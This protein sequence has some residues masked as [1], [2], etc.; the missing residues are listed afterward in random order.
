VKGQTLRDR[1]GLSP[2]E[3]INFR[4]MANTVAGLCLAPHFE[5]LAPEYPSFSVLVTSRNREQYARDALRAIA[6]SMRNTTRQANAVLDALNLLDGNRLNAGQS[7]YVRYILDKFKARPHGQVIN[8]GELLESVDGVDYLAP[9]RYRLEIEWVV[10]LLAALVYSGDIVLAIPGDKFD[11]GKL[12]DLAGTAI[13]DLAAFKHIEPPKD[14]NLPGLQALYELIGL[15]PGLAIEISQGK[16]SSIATLQDKIGTEV[17][18]LVTALHSL[19]E[20]L[21]FW[22]SSVLSEAEAEQYRQQLNTTKTFLESLQAYNTAGKMKNFRHNADDV[23][24][25]EDGLKH[26]AD[27]EKLRS[28]VTELTPLANYLSKAQ[29]VLPLDHEWN[30]RVK[31]ARNDILQQLGSETERGK[32]GFRNQVA[33]RLGEL[34]NEYIRIYSDLYGKARLTLSEDKRK[35]KLLHDERLSRLQALS[36]IEILPQGQ[37]NDFRNRLA[38]LKAAGA[39]SEKDLRADPVP[40]SSDFRP[41][42]EDLSLAAAIK[43]NTLEEQ[44]DQMVGNWTRTLLENLE[45]PTTRH[46]LQ[47]L[48]DDDKTRLDDFITQCELPRPLDDAFVKTLRQVL[49]GL[50]PIEVSADEVNSALFAQASASTVEQLKQRL[51]QFLADKC[52]GQ[53]ISK[54]RIVPK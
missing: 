28:L 46:S 25:H 35:A 31:A 20:R 6:N 48:G 36:T 5:S 4:D 50:V 38:G 11:A 29:A 45:D 37:L 32:S 52:K 33:Q 54:V 18:R 9:D 49:Q 39:L 2:N 7:R 21:P 44:L 12:N 42:D 27:F 51:D 30:E 43:L 22:G 24:A 14:W 13:E 8:R 40:A 15:V 47:L 17:R 1:A 23:R 53:D 3:R 10:V 16:D 26:L 41:I 19:R 34:K